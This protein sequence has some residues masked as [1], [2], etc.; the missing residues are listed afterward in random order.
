VDEFCAGET[1]RPRC[2]GGKNDII[3]MLAARY[4]R[5]SFGRCLVEEPEFAP[6]A[7]NPRF[8][9]CFDDVKRILDQRCSGSSECDVRINDQNFEGIQPCFAGL[10]MH[11]EASYACVKG[12]YYVF[13]G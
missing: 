10:K 12:S 1:F 3:V 4:G 2:A 11:L 13:L 8:V 7:K 9:G 6:M 5:M